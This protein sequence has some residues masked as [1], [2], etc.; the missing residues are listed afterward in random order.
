MSVNFK[1]WSIFL[2]SESLLNTSAW[3]FIKY[4]LNIWLLI[5]VLCSHA[6]FGMYFFPHAFIFIKQMLLSKVPENWTHDADVSSVML[7]FKSFS[8]LCD[9]NIAISR[10]GWGIASQASRGKSS[11]SRRLLRSWP[12]PR[13]IFNLMS[14]RTPLI[15]N[16]QRAASRYW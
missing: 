1:L 4:L 2:K 11:H 16:Q 14:V 12:S 8:W 13:Q 5:R 6:Q 9:R 15:N 3:L 7:D 10:S